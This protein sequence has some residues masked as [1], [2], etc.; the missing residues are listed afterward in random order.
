[1]ASNYDKKIPKPN[2]AKPGTSAIHSVVFP[3]DDSNV[4]TWTATTARRWLKQHDMKPIKHVDKTAN[5]LRYR[6]RPPYWF[7]S[8]STKVITDNEKTKPRHINLVI[9]YY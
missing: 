2:D 8:F 6:I 9:G 1:M 5:T 7:K 4:K 3:I